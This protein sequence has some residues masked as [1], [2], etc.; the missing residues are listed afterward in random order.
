MNTSQAE[1]VARSAEFRLE[2][3]IREFKRQMFGDEAHEEE[4]AEERLAD[5]LARYDPGAP[6]EVHR[7]L[8]KRWGWWKRLNG[9]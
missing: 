5:R 1:V 8:K 4:K 6:S 3:A 9:R 2:N 7:R